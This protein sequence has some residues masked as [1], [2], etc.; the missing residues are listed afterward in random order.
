VASPPLAAAVARWV[1]EPAQD[2]AQTL[3]NAGTGFGV[4]VSGPVALAL[5]DQW[6]WAW[7]VFAC[8]TA[9][10]SWWIHA[11]IP[12]G[13]DASPGNR[14][15]ITPSPGRAVGTLILLVAS[16]LSGLASIA[17]WTFGR[18]LVT[19]QGGADG[20][21]AAAMWTLIGAAG[22]AGALSG[23]L[24]GRLG[25]ETSWGILMVALGAATAGLALAPSSAWVVF[26][27]AAVFGASYIALTGVALVWATRLYRD[28]TEYGVG[29][30][31]LA[32]AAGQAVGAPLA[33]FGAD[34]LG[35]P[36]VFCTCA[37]IALAGGLLPQVG[38][39]PRPRP[40]SATPSTLGDTSIAERQ[41]GTQP[42]SSG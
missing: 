9:A 24:V 27:A 5:L 11:T 40:A 16:F 8:I 41:P 42:T 22:I 31:F 3:V 33:G 39:A 19:V 36:T 35:L 12:R 10:V 18:E 20:L 32:L 30:A 13:S 34:R 25:I 38:A 28:R 4:L 2:R 23:P 7:A 15:D 29:A 26:S 37:A 17:V 1:R 6:R 14:T 21:M